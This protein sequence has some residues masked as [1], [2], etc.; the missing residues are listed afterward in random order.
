MRAEFVHELLEI[1]E[2][3]PRI[4]LVTADLGFSVVEPF[5]E[6][7]PQRF[8]NV[9]VAEQNLIGVATGL[10]HAGFIPYVYSIATFVTMRPYE[11]IRNGPVLH[12]LPVRIVGTG[13]GLDYGHGGVSHYSLE[14][15]AI[16]RAQ[17]GLAIVIPADADQ[18]RAAVSATVEHPGPIYFRLARES[19]PIPEL[20]KEFAMGELATI[21]QTDPEVVL[22]VM[23]TLASEA[24]IAARS[25]S[26]HGLRTSV[27]IVSSFN[28]FPVDQTARLISTAKVVITAESHYRT[29]GLGSATAEVI[30]DRNL[31][32]P[33]V[34]LGIDD[35][36]RGLS[37]S[38]AFLIDHYGLSASS[39]EQRALQ[40][41]AELATPSRNP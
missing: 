16:L 25:L 38:T 34:R 36:P 29:G 23:G 37:G 40:A 12:K 15:V 32:V 1:A 9:G 30:A 8:I 26:A 39:L 17:P 20:A 31:S 7:F 35:M 27:G 28:P 24:L 13:G 33:L 14:D 41:F 19:A 3:D 11:F 22:V 21:G 6:R 4:L 18:A 2:H 10:A 5:A